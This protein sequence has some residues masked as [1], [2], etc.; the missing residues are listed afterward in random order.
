MRILHYSLG[1]PPYRTGGL[2][3][4]SYDLM[5]EQIDNGDNVYLLFPGEIR[6]KN[7]KSKIK[8]YKSVNG[9]KVYEVINP[10][11]VPLLN[12]IVNPNDFMRKADEKIFITYLKKINIDIVH[13]HT[14]MG[15][16]I[17]FLEACKELNIK[18]V[19]STHDYFGLCTKVNFINSNE[20]LC[21]NID[22]SKCIKCNVNGY[23]MTT[24]KILQSSMYRLAKSNGLVEFVKKIN[25][26]YNNNKYKEYYIEDKKLDINEFKNLIEYFR[27]M[28][29]LVDIFLFN[30]TLTKEIYKKYGEFKGQVINITH[31]DIEDLR[32]YKKYNSNKL[33]LTYLGPNKVYKGVNLLYEAMNKLYADGYHDIELNMYG[34]TEFNKVT[35][36]I[37]CYGKY[38]YKDLTN[39]FEKSDILIVPSIWY[40]TYGF[41]VLEALSHGV[42]IMLTDKVGAKDIVLSKYGDKGIIFEDNIE[43]L[44]KNIVRIFENKDILS[45]LNKNIVEDKFEL[46]MKHHYFQVKDKYEEI[47]YG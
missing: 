7:K 10:L 5:S 24:I 23:S 20:Q 8:Y 39:I 18:I 33:R 2:T 3:K 14:F 17:E 46:L 41:I 27:R 43:S 28:F 38:S 29:N 30:S 36:K 31:K 34:D 25:S 42:P 21:E 47:L 19:Y 16:H 32:K 22:F 40:E 37:N 6:L 12:G 4:Y 45:E 35:P 11:P 9:I 13:I 44:Y 15:L 26:K 1:L